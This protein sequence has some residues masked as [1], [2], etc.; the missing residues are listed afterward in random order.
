MRLDVPGTTEL[1]RWRGMLQ[2]STMQG[3]MDVPGT[4]KLVPMPPSGDLSRCLSKL[5]AE[6]VPGMR[7]RTAVPNDVEMKA[8]FIS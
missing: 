4:Q 5:I 2:F 3:P 6:A 7:L 1:V 8:V